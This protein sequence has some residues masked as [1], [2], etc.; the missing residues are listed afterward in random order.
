[1][2]FKQN[3]LEDCWEVKCKGTYLSQTQLHFK[4]IYMKKVFYLTGK[5]MYI[6]T[7]QIIYFVVSTSLS[8]FAVLLWY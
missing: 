8:L 1:M 6:I 4:L 3:K 7:H 5:N 2:K